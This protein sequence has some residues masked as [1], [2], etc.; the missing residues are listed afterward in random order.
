MNNERP[1]PY[2][3]ISGVVNPDQQFY[4]MDHFYWNGLDEPPV[5]RQMA[6]GVKAVHKTQYLDIENK[7]GRDWFPVG[8]EAFSE[9]LRGS[10]PP[11]LKVAQV[12]FDADLVRDVGYR[13]EFVERIRQ[14][15]KTWLSAIQFDLLPWHTDNTILPWLEKVKEDSGLTI[16]LQA[17]GEAM[18]ELGP[19]GIARTLGRHACALDYILFDASHGKGERMN[20]EALLP[21]L[22]QG[23]FSG[24]LLHVGMGVA[25]GLNAAVVGEELPSILEYYPDVSWDAEG[26]LHPTL[27]D[28]SRPIDL[29]R[30]KEYLEASADVLNRYT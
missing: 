23:Y 29:L 16:I 26:Q 5:N 20:T 28:G 8:N 24:N 2:I 13:D 17:H 4:L 22:D 27:P 12:Y 1:K 9:A 14:R 3:G 6:L 10:G 7:Y 15:G 25:G 11:E 21:F 30:A 18:T 19:K